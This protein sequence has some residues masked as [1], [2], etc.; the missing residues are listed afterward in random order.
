MTENLDIVQDYPV[1]SPD[2]LRPLRLNVSVTLPAEAATVLPSLQAVNFTLGAV[3]SM[4]AWVMETML[5]SSV[6]NRYIPFYS[7]IDFKTFE[8]SP[9]YSIFLINQMIPFMKH[10]E[11]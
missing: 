2:L 9:G 4:A 8:K 3:G 7:Q 5:P 10:E 1:K 6:L 11:L